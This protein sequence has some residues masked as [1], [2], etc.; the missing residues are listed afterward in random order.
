[1][2]IRLRSLEPGNTR[3]TLEI[4]EDLTNFHGSPH[5]GAIYSLADAAFAAAYEA[6]VTDGDDERVTSFAGAS[7]SADPSEPG[8]AA[9][10]PSRPDTCRGSPRWPRAP[11]TSPRRRSPPGR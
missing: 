10:R 1:M 8:T 11:R 5:G 3:T 4:T 9:I 7:T 2:G 6:L